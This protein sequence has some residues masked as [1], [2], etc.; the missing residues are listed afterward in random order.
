LIAILFTGTHE[1]ELAPVAGEFA[2]DTDILA[3]NIAA[4]NQTH[5]EQ[6]SNPFGVL[7]IVFVALDSRYPFG[8]C[9]DNVKRSLQDIPNGNPVFASAL[10]ADLLAIVVKEPLLKFKQVSVGSTKV[11]L[12]A[13]G[14][15]AIP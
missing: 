11:L 3:R 14:N 10:H 8:I 12:L 6:I 15:Q 4:G 5:P 2:K 1:Y 9:D 13:L 7:F